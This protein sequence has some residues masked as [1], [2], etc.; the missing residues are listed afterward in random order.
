MAE[1]LECNDKLSEN[2]LITK[3]LEFLINNE[4]YSDVCFCVGIQNIEKSFTPH[5][6]KE[7]TDEHKNENNKDEYII[8]Q[9]NVLDLGIG[10]IA[11]IW[12]IRSILACR[13]PV[14]DSMLYG[15][16]LEGKNNTVIHIPDITS[17]AFLVML[18]Y[19]YTDKIDTITCANVLSTLYAAKKYQL[20]GLTE[21]C[22][23]FIYNKINAKMVFRLLEI[24]KSTPLFY[25]EVVVWICTKYIEKNT[26][27]ILRSTEF[28]NLT[29]E[30]VI[31]IIQNDN[32][33]VISEMS[34]FNS[35][36]RWALAETKRR[37]CEAYPGIL[38]GITSTIVPHIR[39][40]L[41][42]IEQLMKGVQKSGIINKKHI[43]PLA[44]YIVQ[45][46]PNEIKKL[47]YKLR[48]RTN[49]TQIFTYNTDFDKNGL[50]YYLGTKLGT[51]SNF[52][53]PQKLGE[54]KV[55][56]SSV[57]VGHKLYITSRIKKLNTWTESEENSSITINLGEYRSFEL[58]K[59]TLRHGFNRSN[60]SLRN[61]V[62]EGCNTSSKTKVN[63][64]NA[65][66]NIYTPFPPALDNDDHT[67][68]EDTKENTKWTILKEH[69]DD[70][71]LGGNYE[72][73]SWDIT[74][75]KCQPFNKFRIR[76]TGKDH[77]GSNFMTINGIELYGQLFMH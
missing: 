40:P 75:N 7:K 38:R 20:G 37:K 70:E 65:K 43:L 46:N 76:S 15:P 68:V 35:V 39:F 22:I 60:D 26:E 23:I 42:N 13:S 2:N 62:I 73:Q 18:Q 67:N 1:S 21:I 33:N 8:Q 25:Q 34:V 48:P 53:N 29:K 50:I 17:D 19:I 59:Y 30:E 16:M 54:I 12:A 45:K 56:M 5:I 52:T 64:Y 32:I 72:S 3:S 36:M 4:K 47:G 10:T 24:S 51:L 41:M 74:A 69:T 44:I 57:R 61:W 58:T 49:Y 63:H 71:S 9:K 6:C 66:G 11:N 27:I 14:F 28:E 31:S 77:N 55:T